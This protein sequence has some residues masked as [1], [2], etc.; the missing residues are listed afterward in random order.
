MNT[1][2]GISLGELF[3][4]TTAETRRWGAWLREQPHEI[5]NL[6]AGTGRTATVRQLIHHIVIVER[7]YAD[8]L[9]GDP[10]TP[11]ET[12]ADGS[13][14]QLFLAFEDA[15][16]R[17]VEWTRSATEAQLAERI[18]FTT[19]TAGTLEA[20]ARKIVLHTVLHGIRH[21]AQLATVVRQHGYATNWMH[22]VL[23]SD[24]VE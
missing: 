24:A 4:Y 21:W 15:R 18:E 23:M 22:D 12:H 13:I 10:L 6:P 16:A 5:L 19:I 1:G 3:A 8:R 20:S 17:L 7:R 14:D 9:R 11:Y 2:A